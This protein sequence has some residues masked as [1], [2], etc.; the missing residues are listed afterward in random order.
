MVVDYDEKGKPR[1]KSALAHTKEECLQKLETLRTRCGIVT[2]KARP[3]RPFGDW[4]DRWYQELAKPRFRPKSREDY[5]N[6]IYNHIVPRIGKVPLNKNSME[7]LQQ[8]YTELRW[9]KW[10]G[11]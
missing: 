1:T 7:I 5:E 4:L 3:D 2:G 11:R 10:K 9:R 8:F 6:E